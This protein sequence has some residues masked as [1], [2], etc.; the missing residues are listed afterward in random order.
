MNKE[1][2]VRI[3][4]KTDTDANFTANDPVLLEGEIV[5]VKTDSE[6]T[7]LKIGDGK[8]PY[9]KL[10]FFSSEAELEWGTWT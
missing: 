2:Q 1:L 10:P 7:K 8:T 3:K 4:N 5:V 9:T 6:G